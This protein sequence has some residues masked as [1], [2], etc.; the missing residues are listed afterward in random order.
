MSYGGSP[1]HGGSSRRNSFYFPDVNSS[2]PTPSPHHRQFYPVQTPQH[3]QRPSTRAHHRHASTGFAADFSLNHKDAYRPMTAFSPAFSPRQDSPRYDSSGKYR[4]DP[5]ATVKTPKVSARK[6]SF[7]S[8]GAHRD[9]HH[10][11]K[12]D[13]RN[14]YSYHRTSHGD[15][16]EDEIIEADGFIY[17]IPAPS[18]SRKHGDAYYYYTAPGRATNHYYPQERRE[19]YEEPD[20][21][22]VRVTTRDRLHVSQRDHRDPRDP[23]PRAATRM[24][25]RTHTRRPSTSQHIPRPSTARPSSSHQVKSKKP[26][27]PVTREATLTDAEEHHIPKGFSLKNWDPAEQP[28][29]LLGS[30]FDANSLG[31]WIYDW[32]VY[33]HGP[34]TP[35]SNMAGE[36]WLLLIQLSGKLKHAEEIAPRIRVLDNKDMVEDFIESGERLT[37]KLQ[38]LLKKCEAPMLQAQK[39]KDAAQL[40]MNSG[41][42][43]VMTLWGRDRELEKTERFMSSARLWNLRF[44]ANCDAILKNPTK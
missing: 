38:S 6:Q 43:F 28:I 13:R 11:P 22:R 19:Y 31:K 10:T 12:R 44:D 39:K 35:I 42:Q 4:T 29:L 15:S 26:T 41:I 27:P 5:F 1:Y 23:L 16:D 17:V 32:T 37:D 18:R 21:D 40:G 8:K 30:V 2:S 25:Q 24:E 9:H 20:Y 34:D 7:S 36:L 33:H 14:S 3:Q